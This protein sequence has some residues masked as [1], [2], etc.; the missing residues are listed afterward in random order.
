MQPTIISNEINKTWEQ[1]ILI[2][3]SLPIWSGQSVLSAED[4]AAL[5]FQNTDRDVL[6]PGTKKLVDPESL[7]R[8]HTIRSTMKN[9]LDRIGLSTGSGYAVP[10]ERSAEALE[11]VDEA[12]KAYERAVKDFLSGYEAAVDAWIE[13][14]PATAGIIRRGR[15]ST[16][17][18]EERFTPSYTTFRFSPLRPEDEAQCQGA[19]EKLQNDLLDDVVKKSSALLARLLAAVQQQIDRRGL[20]T[21]QAQRDRLMGLSFLAG[22]L[23]HLVDM[24]DGVLAAIPPSGPIFGSAFQKLLTCASIL[25]NGDLLRKFV[26]GEITFPEQFAAATGETYQSSDM[27]EAA[28]APVA[29]PK[30]VQ[31]PAPEA[32]FEPT[33]P[34]EVD[35]LDQTGSIDQSFYGV[36]DLDSMAAEQAAAGRMTNDL[37]DLPPAFQ[38]IPPAP[39]PAEK[40]PCQ[41]ELFW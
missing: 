38:P 2:K 35:P 11:V 4:E 27:F 28:D 18:V 39:K 31:K 13:K 5:G 29:M 3:I 8:F 24:I 7:K 25:A 41:E 17:E 21:L 10:L 40:V 19:M 22:G 9:N 14:N 6:G 37:H 26:D 34:D 12:I 15:L 33:M 1:V 36:T 32:H 30:T 20:S 23:V 16:A